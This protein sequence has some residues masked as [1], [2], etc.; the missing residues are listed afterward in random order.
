MVLD[1]VELKHLPHITVDKECAIITDNPV[2][3][4]KPHN[5]VLLDEVCYCFSYGFTEWYSLCPLSE[6]F[7]SHQDPYVSMRRWVNWPHQIKPPSVEG[8]WSDHAMQALQVSINQVGL[9]LAT[10]A[11]FHKF[12]CIFLHGWPVVTHLQQASIQLFLPLVFPTLSW[13]H[14][15]YHLFCFLRAQTS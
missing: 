9:Y 11:F 14:L 5:Y 12:R 6:V 2:E 7:R 3:Y 1:L 13:V 15:F 4:P 8:L 10:V